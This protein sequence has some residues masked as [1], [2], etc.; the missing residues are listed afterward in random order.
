MVDTP[1]EMLVCCL[2]VSSD[3]FAVAKAVKVNYSRD[4]KYVQLYV[5]CTRV[6]LLQYVQPSENQPTEHTFKLPASPPVGSVHIKSTSSRPVVALG[7]YLPRPLCCV[8]G[9]LMSAI[10]Y[11]NM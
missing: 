3:R 10:P 7:T 6:G 11:Y 9:K 1:C 5:E 8:V 4:K 2:R